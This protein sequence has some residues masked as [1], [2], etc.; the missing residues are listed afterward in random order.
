MYNVLFDFDRNTGL[1]SGDDPT[2]G[3]PAMLR[4]S[5]N[6]LERGLGPPYDPE[7]DPEDNNWVDLGQASTLLLHS[8]PDPGDIFI[9]LAPDARG[10]FPSATAT[11]HVVVSFGRPAAFQQPQASPFTHDGR[12][13]GNI[14]TTF[15]F[16]P[17]PRKRPADLKS[18]WSFKLGGIAKRPRGANQARL[19]HR[20]QFS[21]GVIAKDALKTLTYGEDPDMD[22]GE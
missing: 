12:D 16:G 21:V 4:K 10:T 13:T 20:Y 9:R 17:S 11:L 3:A 8:L 1:F 2:P 22:I 6:W 7:N 19:S 18:G 15:S 5:G 14:I